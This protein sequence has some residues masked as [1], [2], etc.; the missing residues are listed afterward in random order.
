M[1]LGVG[2]RKSISMVNLGGKLNILVSGRSE[3]QEEDECITTGWFEL[4][5]VSRKGSS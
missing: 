4:V 3:D 1:Q 2:S 5:Q